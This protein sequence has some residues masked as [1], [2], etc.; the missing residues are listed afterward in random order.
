M[1]SG[2]LYLTTQ[3]LLLAISMCT[4]L[5][6]LDIHTYKHVKSYH[7]GMDVQ[8]TKK[9]CVQ[10]AVLATK[11]EVLQLQAVHIHWTMEIDL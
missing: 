1:V 3:F 10:K 9:F 8:L 11:M 4:C 5:V 6:S 2:T 7:I